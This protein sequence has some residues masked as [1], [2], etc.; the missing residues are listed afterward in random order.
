MHIGT[1]PPQ[2]ISVNPKT[3]NKVFHF[4]PKTGGK[5][6]VDTLFKIEES[7][8]TI[9][10]NSAETTAT[11]KSTIGTS[12]WSYTVGR[13][14]GMTRRKNILEGTK[15]T[16]TSIQRN[17]LQDSVRP[18]IISAETT[19]GSEQSSKHLDLRKL[20]A[21]ISK[22]NLSQPTGPQ[23]GPGHLN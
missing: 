6:D 11:Q 8:K 22:A 4:S 10:L 17:P 23:K 21:T 13:Q 14:W 1:Q 20:D 7:D 16:Y 19:T 18:I 15:S 9:S 12:H 3:Q 2:Y 5:R